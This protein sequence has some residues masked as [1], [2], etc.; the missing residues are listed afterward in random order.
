[1]TAARLMLYAV[2]SIPAVSNTLAT[3]HM[4][5]LGIYFVA[6]QCFLKPEDYYFQMESCA[7]KFKKV[8]KFQQSL[9]QFT[10][11]C[12]GFLYFLDLYVYL[13]R[14]AVIQPN[15][16]SHLSVCIKLVAVHASQ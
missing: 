4:W 11:K 3:S 8:V 13:N 1:M 2:C 15:Y 6:D 16:N 14:G 5:L 7:N 10:P 12:S 9:F